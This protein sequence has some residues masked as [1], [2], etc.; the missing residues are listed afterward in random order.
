MSN[1]GLMTTRCNDAFGKLP[2]HKNNFRSG[3]VAK[4]LCR[5]EAAQCANA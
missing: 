5:A 4:P 1:H 3:T 2:H